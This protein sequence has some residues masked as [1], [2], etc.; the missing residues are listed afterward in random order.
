[1]VHLLRRLRSRRQRSRVRMPVPGLRHR[2]RW[3]DRRRRNFG[4][5]RA[6]F[7][8]RLGGQPR[9][10]RLLASAQKDL[11]IIRDFEVILSTVAAGIGTIKQSSGII[12]KADISGKGLGPR[13]FPP[14]PPSSHHLS[15]G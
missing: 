8:H 5:L 6:G 1:M 7:R 2:E 10:R 15:T 14:F 3:M 12:T 9:E 11:G 13:P 4:G